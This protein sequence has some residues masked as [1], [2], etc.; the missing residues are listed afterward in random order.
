MRNPYD[1]IKPPGLVWPVKGLGGLGLVC[2]CEESLTPQCDGGVICIGDKISCCFQAVWTGTT[3]DW[4]CLS[5]GWKISWGITTTFAAFGV[6]D[7]F[8]FGFNTS[9]RRFFLIDRAYG[10]GAINYTHGSWQGAYVSDDIDCL[11][12][13]EILKYTTDMEWIAG[14][15]SSSKTPYLKD[16]TVTCTPLL[17]S[18]DCVDVRNCNSCTCRKSADTMSIELNGSVSCDA[19]HFGYIPSAMVVNNPGGWYCTGDVTFYNGD[20]GIAGMNYDIGGLVRF[21]IYQSVYSKSY[22]TYAK[23]GPVP[24]YSGAVNTLPLDSVVKGSVGYDCSWPSSV[25]VT[26]I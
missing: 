15:T 16:S 4:A 5:L 3:G 10:Y 23:A 6:S 13:S 14:S 24:C 18:D 8:V 12:A 25:T 17:S 1:I 11:H 20:D 19:G 21:G 22:A 26:Y 2:C 7:Q 9:S